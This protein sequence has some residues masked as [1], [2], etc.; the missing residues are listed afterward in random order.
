MCVLDLFHA[1]Y[2]PLSLVDPY[3]DSDIFAVVRD[4]YDRMVSEF[5]YACPFKR[6]CSTQS[7]MDVAY[8]NRWIRNMLTAE[9]PATRGHFAPQHSFVVGPNEV[10]MVDH[11]LRMENLVEDFARLTGAYYPAGAV[12]LTEKKNVKGGGNHLGGSS[13]DSESLRMINVLF[14][15]DA[16]AFG[17]SRRANYSSSQAVE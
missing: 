14:P 9:T 16:V 7:M 11:V 5:N 13:L 15:D 1:E 2:F 17:Y 3:G 4:P 10:R 12:Q 6:E 8:M